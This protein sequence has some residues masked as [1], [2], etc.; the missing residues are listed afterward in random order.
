MCLINSSHWAAR[1]PSDDSAQRTPSI[2]RSAEDGTR[3]KMMCCCFHDRHHHRPKKFHPHHHRWDSR[4]HWDRFWTPWSA[5]RD[6]QNENDARTR[7]TGLFI[8]R[9]NEAVDQKARTLLQSDVRVGDLW[10]E[11]NFSPGLERN[12]IFNSLTLII[13]SINRIGKLLE[14]FWID[15]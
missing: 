2:A 4:C 3:M 1:P 10:T 9:E 12:N 11:L 8:H 5:R 7:N 6:I 15:W 14:S 13:N